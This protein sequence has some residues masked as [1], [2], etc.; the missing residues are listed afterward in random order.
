MPIV[1]VGEVLRAGVEDDDFRDIP[2]RRVDGMDVQL[3]EGG[4]EIALL[5]RRDGLVLEEQDLVGDEGI[6]ELG[7]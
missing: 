2:D 5:L 6:T 4:G 1:V 7:T 3:A